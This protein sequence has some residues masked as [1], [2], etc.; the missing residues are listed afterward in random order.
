M[1]LLFIC[2]R[3]SS[4]YSLA[5]LTQ[6]IKGA[7]RKTRRSLCRALCVP[8]WSRVCPELCLAVSFL[9][10]ACCPSL[11]SSLFSPLQT[12]DRGLVLSAPDS[13]RA[14]PVSLFPKGNVVEEQGRTDLRVSDPSQCPGGLCC[15][16]PSTLTILSELP[17]QQPHAENIL[18]PGSAHRKG[19]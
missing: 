15:E 5:S 8:T 18:A 11:L 9:V 2:W 17:E 19:G 10:H 16:F 1:P 13:A 14:P 12:C 3:E 7:F 4:W 6:R